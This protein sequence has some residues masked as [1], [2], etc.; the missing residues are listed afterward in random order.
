MRT[1]WRGWR[2]PGRAEPN[3]T[4]PITAAGTI[5]VPRIGLHGGAGGPR[6][7]SN[8]YA[9][10][11]RLDRLWWVGVT[12]LVI[13]G[14]AMLAWSTL[15]WSR[16]ALTGDFATYHQAWWLI[17]HGHLDPLNT[18]SAGIPFWRD[19]FELAI[20]PLAVVGLVFPHGPVLLWIQDL[21]LVGAE[22]VAWRWMCEAASAHGGRHG[23]L[24]AAVGLV[25]ILADPWSWWAIS[26]DFHME[27][28]AAL[29]VLLAAYDLA[30]HR[31]RMWLWVVATLPWGAVPATY[32]AGLGLAALLAGR[33]WR[34]YGVC[35]LATG[36]MW[37][38]LVTLVHAN[39]GVSST[40]GYLAGSGIRSSPSLFSIVAGMGTHPNRLLSALWHQRIDIWANLAPAG[41]V[42]VVTPWTLGLALP[43]LLANNLA[44]GIYAEP[45]FQSTVLYVIVPLGTVLV[46]VHLHGRWPKTALAVGL[47]AVANALAWGA[48]WTP[49]L[50]TTWLRVS[51]SA[52]A[53]LARADTLIPP[54]A[55]VI[56]SQ[57]VVG[58]F[59]DRPLVYAVDGPAEQIPLRSGDTWW[60][61]A[62]SVGVEADPALLQ[63]ALLAEL[64]GPLHARLVL[65]GHGVWV[66]HWVP[67]ADRRSVTLPGT[68]AH[69]P[70]WIFAGAAGVPVLTGRSSGWHLASTGARGYVLSGDYWRDPR[71]P[72]LVTVTLSCTDPV[73]VEVWNAT[74]N[75][76][77]ARRDV[78]PSGGT[79]AVAL[80][81]DAARRFP[82]H[83]FRGW[84]PFQAQFVAPPPQDQLEVRIW[85]SGK[86]VVDI[87]QVRVSRGRHS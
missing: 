5:P 70:A 35:L 27:V 1:A 10:A 66:F 56:A 8:V 20:W 42:G 57:G 73:N 63:D 40:Y 69:V 12:L 51:T 16:F 13:Q 71:G 7:S 68:P 43:V 54:A 37:L 45:V 46:L 21:A 15:L 49:T 36:L 14:V 85:T 84:G 4:D 6:A 58:R 17:A 11:P 28:G 65:H 60:V 32:V 62:P 61:V 31:R 50:T 29:F 79:E 81:A 30:H 9:Q 34:R 86:G 48:I 87:E 74:G 77:L 2:P 44:G 26:W 39:V 25:L 64:S 3:P 18:V 67:P 82:H 47:I 23:R 53:E 19:H 33:L 80:R 24:L 78:P 72:L 75:V 83:I 22:V 41:L 59:S 55:E 76:L 38:A 52:A